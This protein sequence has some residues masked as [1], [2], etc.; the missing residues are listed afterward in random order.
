MSKT[1]AGPGAP[2]L[3]FSVRQHPCAIEGTADTVSQTRMLHCCLWNVP[4]RHRSPPRCTYSDLF[5]EKN[6]GRK[7]RGREVRRESDYELYLF[8]KY[9]FYSQYLFIPIFVFLGVYIYCLLSLLTLSMAAGFLGS[10]MIGDSG[11]IGGKL[12]LLPSREICVF[13]PGGRST[14]TLELILIPPGP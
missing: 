8:V 4:P 11:L 12:G 9:L 3:R 13:L 14:T 7:K 2:S 10:L 1:W 5:C 6:E